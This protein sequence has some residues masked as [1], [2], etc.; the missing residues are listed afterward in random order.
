MA[1][2]EHYGK[3]VWSVNRTEPIVIRDELLLPINMTHLGGVTV[4]ENCLNLKLCRILAVRYTAAC[5]KTHTMCIPKG[6]FLQLLV[7]LGN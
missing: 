5:Y 6:P 4:F 2:F 1:L 3:W 7:A